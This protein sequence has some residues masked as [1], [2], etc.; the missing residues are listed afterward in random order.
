MSQPFLGQ[1]MQVGFNFAPTGWS[2]CAGQQVSISQNSA[3]FS[4]LGTTF[5][6]NGTSTFQLPDLQGRV[7]VGTGASTT[8]AGT[9]T[10]GEVAGTQSVTLTQL[11]LPSHIHQATF[12][13]TGGGGGNPLQVTVNAL[14]S[15]AGNVA[16]PQANSMLTDGGVGASAAKI[17]SPAGATGTQVALGGVTASGGG[18][19]TGGTVAVAATGNNQPVSILQPYL[20][21]FNIIAMQGIFPSRP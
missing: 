1:I 14:T 6:G 10:W 2:T 5:G 21:V 4:L 19:I 20:S 18:G 16:T 13:G 3:L 9:Y 11:Q 12:T 8:G 15:S 7:A 17:Y